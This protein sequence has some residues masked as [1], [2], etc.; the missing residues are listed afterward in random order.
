MRRT[1]P[2]VIIGQQLRK[3]QHARS[4]T[5]TEEYIDTLMEKE[6]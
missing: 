3:V 5:V 4:K 2:S 6:A 1:R